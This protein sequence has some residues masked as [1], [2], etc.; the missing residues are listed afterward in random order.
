METHHDLE[1]D[2]N[3]GRRL[4]IAETDFKSGTQSEHLNTRGKEP[5]KVVTRRSWVRPLIT[6]LYPLILT[7]IAHG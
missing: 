5:Q 1:I 6:S 3:R 4:V 2:G 7:G